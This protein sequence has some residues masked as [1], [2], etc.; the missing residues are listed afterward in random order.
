MSRHTGAQQAEWRKLARVCAVSFVAVFAVMIG[1]GGVIM[2]SRAE[3]VEYRSE[4]TAA[5]K[6]TPLMKDSKAYRALGR[7]L[8]EAVKGSLG[9]S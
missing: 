7:D 9:Q 3:A 8:I 1:L 6:D 2:H 4:I 5:G